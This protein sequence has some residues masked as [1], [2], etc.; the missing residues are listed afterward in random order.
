MPRYSTMGRTPGFVD[1]SN[2]NN[3]NNENYDDGMIIANSYLVSKLVIL[4]MFGWIL[5]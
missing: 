1:D 3:N 5:T 4:A 2:N